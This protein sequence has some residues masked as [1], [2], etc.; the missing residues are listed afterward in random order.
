[1]DN[2]QKDGKKIWDNLSRSEQIKIA[3]SLSN[4]NAK[5]DAM[6][7]NEVVWH[8]ASKLGYWKIKSKAPTS[9][10]WNLI[11]KTNQREVFSELNKKND[12]LKK[13]GIK[14][15]F[16]TKYGKRIVIKDN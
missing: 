12:L 15:R 1:M 11:H 13:Y 4:E 7:S 10:K 16:I 3:R 9:K 14:R 6:P 2:W 5:A 8:N